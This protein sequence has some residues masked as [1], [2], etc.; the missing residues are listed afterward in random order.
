MILISQVT[1]KIILY[2]QLAVFLK[3]TLLLAQ[4]F[5]GLYVLI[6]ILLIFLASNKDV[7][8]DYKIETMQQ[9]IKNIGLEGM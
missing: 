7:Q 2:Q 4:N 8:N 6:Y 1:G 3:V 5:N 9:Q